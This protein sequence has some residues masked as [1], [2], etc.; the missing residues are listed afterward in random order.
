MWHVALGSRQWIHQVAYPTTWYVALGWHVTEFAKT[1]AILEFYFWSRF[2]PYHCSRHVIL[3][4]SAKFLSKLDHTRQEKM[5]SCRFPRWR[6]SAILDFMGSI[7]RTLKSPCTTSYRSSIETT[8][9]NCLVLRKSRFCILATDR[10]TGP[11]DEAALAAASGGLTKIELIWCTDF[12]NDVEFVTNALTSCFTA[13]LRLS[14][15]SGSTFWNSFL[16]GSFV[17]AIDAKSGLL[18]FIYTP[19]NLSLRARIQGG[20]KNLTAFEIR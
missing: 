12:A 2:R 11:L 4:Q 16:P 20:P 18:F 14:R 10:W 1:S 5:T 13:A 6:I 9:L 7:M 19:C 15:S 3:Y 8:A 17:T